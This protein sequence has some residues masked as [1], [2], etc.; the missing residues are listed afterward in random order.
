LIFFASIWHSSRSRYIA[1]LFGNKSRTS[2]NIHWTWSARY[3]TRPAAREG[4]RPR[5][6][7]T[8]KRPTSALPPRQ[9]FWIMPGFSLR[10]NAPT[11]CGRKRL[12]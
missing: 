4:N 12:S 1:A 10:R 3:G 6:R 8:P 5:W 7:L 2:L 11:N 9:P